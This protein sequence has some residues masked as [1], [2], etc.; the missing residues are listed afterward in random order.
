MIPGYA[1]PAHKR[2]RGKLAEIQEWNEA[3]P[4]NK[5][6]DGGDGLGI[7]A[8]GISYVHAREAAP[9]AAFLKLGTTYPLPMKK[10]R[11]FVESVKRCIVIEE[12]DPYLVD[13]IR[14]AGVQVDSKQE[15]YRFD[16]LNVTRVK[17]IL[18]GD[19]SPEP[20]RPPG[21]PPQLCP[22]CP[23][24]TVLGAL[25]KLDCIISGD[26]GC[27]TLG[28]LPPIEAHD[29]CVCM[30]ASITTGLGLRH[31]LP[32]EEARRVVSVIGDSTF[33]HSGITGLVEMVYNPPKTGHVVVILDNG[34]TAMTG[35]QEH[36]GTGWTLEHLPTGRVVFE[37][38]AR[39]LGVKQVHVIDPGADVAAFEKLVA[40]SLA[41]SDTVLII[42]RRPCNLAAKKLETLRKTAEQTHA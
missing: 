12:N 21:K 2:L 33:V 39:A 40:D 20:T 1:R 30:G 38:L 19:V 6:I 3:S 36:P 13:A 14:A 37:D 22:A 41:G 42:A 23:H 4:M 15:M 11:K 25:R 29:S 16:E 26:I 17:R 8:S 7:I 27:Y 31:V 28:V 35:M 18:A 34:T 9:G 24:R 5:V 32:P 10:I